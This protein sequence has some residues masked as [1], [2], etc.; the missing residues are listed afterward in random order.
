MSMVDQPKEWST[1]DPVN[2]F[3]LNRLIFFF[4]RRIIELRM[5]ILSYSESITTN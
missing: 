4:K 2:Y 3:N 1:I 5:C